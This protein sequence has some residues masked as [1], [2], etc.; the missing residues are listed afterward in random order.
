MNAGRP[1]S[2]SPF[3]PYEFLST[4]DRGGAGEVYGLN[5]GAC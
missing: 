1:P 3:G 4:L 2:Q 5:K